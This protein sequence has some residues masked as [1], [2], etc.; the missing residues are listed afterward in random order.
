[1]VKQTYKKQQKLFNCNRIKSDLNTIYKK[2]KYICYIKSTSFGRLTVFQIKS[3]K[4]ILLKNQ[5]LSDLFL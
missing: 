2:T 4:Q 5:L 1:M 3:F